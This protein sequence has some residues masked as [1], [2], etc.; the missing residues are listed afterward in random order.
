MPTKRERTNSNAEQ[1]ALGYE[2]YDCI[3]LPELTRL[4]EL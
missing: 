4:A 2:F 1:A 3:D